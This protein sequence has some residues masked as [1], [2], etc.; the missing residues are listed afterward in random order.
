MVQRHRD[1]WEEHK[2]IVDT[3]IGTKD[4]ETAKLAKITAETLKIRQEAE[5]KA[6][7]I[8]AQVAPITNVTVSQ[9][10]GP[11]AS[12]DEIRDVLKESAA[13]PKV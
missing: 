8:D 7:G 6:W 12:V 10:G 9:I 11:Q 3:A 13:A 5:R 1:E 2:E 4:F